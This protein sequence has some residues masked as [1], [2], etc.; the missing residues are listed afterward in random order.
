MRDEELEL[1]LSELGEQRLSLDAAALAASVRSG[2]RARRRQRGGVVVAA[3]L[4]SVAGVGALWQPEAAPDL[5]V[6]GESVA[7]Q[8][9]VEL[10]GP[11]AGS[12]VEIHYGPDRSPDGASVTMAPGFS[13][14][15]T[16]PAEPTGALADEA[17]G[18]KVNAT[19]PRW[20]GCLV[21]A[22]LI[23][24]SGGEVVVEASFYAVAGGSVDFYV[25]EEQLGTSVV[26]FGCLPS[27]GLPSLL[28]IPLADLPITPTD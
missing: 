2:S 21:R 18:F 23:D 17:D 4:L 5:V 24:I 15:P 11:Q 1:R 9:A 10:L 14:I 26:A 13:S 8:V 22:A 20:S 3:A 27:R 7:G 6:L 16:K 28:L 19:S 12:S 25:D